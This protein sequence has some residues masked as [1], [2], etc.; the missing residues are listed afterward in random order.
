MV[1]VGG[2]CEI[3][4]DGGVAVSRDH[5]GA[6]QVLRQ[7]RALRDQAGRVGRLRGAGEH[8]VRHR[9]MRFQVVEFEPDFQVVGRLVFELR[10]EAVMRVAVHFLVV[11]EVMHV[12][13]E[14]AGEYGGDA[15]KVGSER[16]G[17][18]AFE[19]VFAAAGVAGRV[20]VGMQVG[21]RLARGDVDHAG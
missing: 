6:G 16:A 5:A 3:V 11:V 1:V 13:V 4:V 2:A 8:A 15:G 7:Q 21:R 17:D 19:A 14:A 18:A 9:V 12:A 10:A 20:G